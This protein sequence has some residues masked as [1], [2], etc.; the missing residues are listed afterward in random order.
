MWRRGNAS[1]HRTVRYSSDSEDIG[2]R[3]VRC[4][5]FRVYLTWHFDPQ[6][7][8]LNQL[9]RGRRFADQGDWSSFLIGLTRRIAISPAT[10]IIRSHHQ[11]P[12]SV[13]NNTKSV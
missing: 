2:T 6:P 13:R 8:L 9:K 4:R 1:I 5:N 12:I 3:D 11:M 10:K 7:E